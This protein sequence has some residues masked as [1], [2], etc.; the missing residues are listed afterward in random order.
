MRAWL[1][2]WRTWP[3]RKMQGWPLAV[4][5]SGSVWIGAV[6]ILE[7]QSGQREERITLLERALQEDRVALDLL[8][9]RLEIERGL[10]DQSITLMRETYDIVVKREVRDILRGGQKERKIPLSLLEEPPPPGGS[11]GRR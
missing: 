11:K 5:I 6:M 7:Y 2:A 9:K 4:L 3:L 8:A 1:R 10:L